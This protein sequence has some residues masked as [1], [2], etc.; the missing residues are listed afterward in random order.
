[1][2]WPAPLSLFDPVLLVI[3][4]VAI[5]LAIVAFVQI[6]NSNGTQTGRGLAALGL[7]LALGFIGL[8]GGRSL[9]DAFKN[10]EDEKAIDSLIIKLDELLVAHKYD[11][12]YQM[13]DDKFTERFKQPD[14]V[15]IWKHIVEGSKD[16]KGMTGMH[17]NNRMEFEVNADTGQ[18]RGIE[19]TIMEFGPN[20]TRIPF[21][22]VQEPD[23]TW[24]ITD[25]PDLFKQQQPPPGAPPRRW[26]ISLDPGD[27]FLRETTPHSVSRLTLDELRSLLNV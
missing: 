20:S 22:F 12:A 5:V 14:F 6:R 10:R 13:F 18:K 4:A 7:V 17:P 1:M 8:V 2:A 23:G 11:E 9:S 24:K 19:M 21:V 25:I 26:R 3:P 27:S 16:Y 15:G